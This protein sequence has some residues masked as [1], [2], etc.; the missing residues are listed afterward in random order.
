MRFLHV[1]PGSAVAQTGYPPLRPP[2]SPRG[3]QQTHKWGPSK[4]Q[5]PGAERTSRAGKGCEW[6]PGLVNIQKNMG[7]NVIYEKEWI[8]LAITSFHGH[9]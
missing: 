3:C 8:F 1:N 6:L 7:K 4:A 2:Y 5:R 9:L